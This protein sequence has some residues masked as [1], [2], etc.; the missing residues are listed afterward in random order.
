M[1]SDGQFPIHNLN[2]FLND[3]D[4]SSEIN[5]GF[6]GSRKVKKDS[7]IMRFGS[8]WSGKLLNIVYHTKYQDFNS[9]FMFVKASVLKKIN[10]EAKGLNYSTEITFCKDNSVLGKPIIISKENKLIFGSNIL[11]Y[12]TNINLISSTILNEQKANTH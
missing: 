4:K 2:Y 11:L 6:N 10:L 1:D 8:K 3:L 5:I 7:F 9:A 12:Y